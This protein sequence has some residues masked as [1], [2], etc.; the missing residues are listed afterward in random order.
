MNVKPKV[1]IVDDRVR[2]L[3]VLEEMLAD[4]GIDLVRATSGK[5]AI[6]K[7]RN[8]EF[9][10]VL[11][12][13]RMPGMDGFEAVEEIR[14]DPR[15]ELLPIIYITA[16]YH[17]DYYKVKGIRTGAVDFI[18]KPIIPDVLQGKV[19]VFTRLYRQRKNLEEEILWREQIEKD[20]KKAKEL[21]EDA[22]RAKQKFLSNMSHEIRTPLNAIINTVN[23]MHEGDPQAELL[24]NM[25]ILKFSA[26]SLLQ[27][28][29][30]ILDYS[31]IDAGRIEFEKVEFE[32]RK[33]LTGVKQSFDFEV[34]RRNLKMDVSLDE[35]IPMVVLGDSAR[36]TQILINLVGNAVKFTEKGHIAIEAKPVKRH[37]SLIDIE[38]RITD[39]G[40]GIPKDKLEM[41][42]ESFTQASSSTTRKYGGTGLGL[43]ITQ[44][45]VELQGGALQVKSKVG[46]G[47]TFH[48][49]LPFLTSDKT[50]VEDD[51]QLKEHYH[52]LKGL[53]V[54]VVED[55]LVNQK[56]VSKFLSR[57]E[58]AY[59][60]A[61]NG[62][63]AVEKVIKTHFDL[64]L[65]DLHMPEMSGYEATLKIRAMDGEY[66]K[67]L[68]II[69]L[70]ASVFLEDREKIFDFGMSGFVTKPFNPKELFWTI[71]PF[72]KKR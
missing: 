42:F 6:E 34:N 50:H 65:M 4:L 9:A 43:A 48:F 13:I 70:T 64:V 51:A 23:L 10:L 45:L 53:K 60:I 72:L 54:L 55:N 66:F 25:E 22:T 29:N 3:I 49:T 63:I 18:T 27:I 52:S 28:V 35:S 21:A 11:M 46:K 71:S 14:K 12:D 61:E 41:I 58:A 8:T 38:F 30:D 33:L 16:F 57:W 68:P 17:E 26:D 15:N 5:E 39:T 31:K 24:D 56:I 40:I 32:M 67:E 59:E 37:N 62:R 36:L 2:N 20:L 47:S 19:T 69:A 44:K 7:T 1:L